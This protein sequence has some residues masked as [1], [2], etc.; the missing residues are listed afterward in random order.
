MATTTLVRQDKPIRRS[1]RIQ[2]QPMTPVQ[3]QKLAHD[4]TETVM[5]GIGGIVTLKACLNES[6]D[7][8]LFMSSLKEQGKSIKTSSQQKK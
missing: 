6:F 2:N 3:K 8:D 7:I 5:K 4:I 1:A